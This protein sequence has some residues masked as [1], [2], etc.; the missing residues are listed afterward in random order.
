MTGQD[1]HDD[2]HA[3]VAPLEREAVPGD[4]VLVRRRGDRR[5][6]RRYALTAVAATAVVA[7]AGGV[8]LSQVPRVT[9]QEPA[10]VASARTA[11]PA[12]PPTPTAAA[13]TVGPAQ[14]LR[15][16]DV[17]TRGGPAL[18]TAPAGAGRVLDEV[19]VCVPEGL[20]ALR[21]TGT[22]SRSFRYPGQESV[23]VQ[24][25]ALQFPDADAARRAEQTVQDWVAGCAATIEDAGG[26]LLDPADEPV[27][28]AVD[29]PSGT[30]GGFAVLP[31]YRQQGGE[32]SDEGVFETLGTTRVADRLMLSVEVVVGMDD[33]VSLQAGGDPENGLPEHPQFG[34]VRAAAER[35]AVE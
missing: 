22:A 27:R 2:L 17:P 24:T 1:L 19:S 12:P 35:L 33:N 15:P 18:E 32:S 6:H 21:A 13:R 11:V 16:A 25:V 5:R 4:P 7:L 14:L 10:P 31:T 9:D 20:A 8:A 29:T 28:V 3:L 30:S 26:T 23:A 34:L